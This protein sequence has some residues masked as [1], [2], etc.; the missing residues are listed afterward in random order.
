M[1][2]YEEKDVKFWRCNRCDSL[3]LEIELVHVKDEVFCDTCGNTI[4][5]IK[6][7]DKYTDH[8]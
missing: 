5:L 1:G 2:K 4:D 6:D 3:L 8:P 7:L